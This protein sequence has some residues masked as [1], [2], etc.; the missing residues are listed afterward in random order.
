MGNEEFVKMYLNSVGGTNRRE[1][2]LGRWKDRMKEYVSEKGVRGYG[3][4][5][6]RRQYMERER[7]R[8]ICRGHTV[9]GLFLGGVRHQGY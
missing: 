9:G 2:S 7:W 6:A 3:L 4:E 5:W 8:S 1:R